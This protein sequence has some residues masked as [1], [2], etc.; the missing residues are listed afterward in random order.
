LRIRRGSTADT[1]DGRMLVAR[2]AASVAE[3]M[4]R[5]RDCARGDPDET[6]QEK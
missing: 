4:H 1:V 2:R 3:R 6:S 5:W